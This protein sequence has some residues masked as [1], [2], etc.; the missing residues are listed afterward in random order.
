[1]IQVK[2]LIQLLNLK[3]HPE[4]GYFRETYRSGKTIPSSALP[5]KYKG[6]RAYSTCILYLLPGGSC[7]RWHRLLSDEVWHFYIGAPLTLTQISPKGKLT[8]TT[9]GPNATKGQKFQKAVPAGNWLAASPLTGGSFSLVGCTVAPGFEYQDLE[10]A[11]SSELL[12][13]FPGLKKTILEFLG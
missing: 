7:S 4:G 1:M 11:D 8:Q 12:K 9:L 3:P 5:R 10:I 13:R 2:K 6:K